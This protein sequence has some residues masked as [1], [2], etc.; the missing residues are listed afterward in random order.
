MYFL[1]RPRET[2]ARTLEPTTK[3]DSR[4]VSGPL[5]D[6][7]PC[8]RDHAVT[9]FKQAISS[10][11]RYSYWPYIHSN[12]TVLTTRLNWLVLP[13]RRSFSRT[14]WHKEQYLLLDWNGW[15]RLS[16]V[17]LPESLASAHIQN[18]P[19]PHIGKSAYW[20]RFSSMI[21]GR[22]RLRPLQI[23]LQPERGHTALALGP[24]D[25][26]ANFHEDWSKN[27]PVRAPRRRA[28]FDRFSQ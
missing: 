15:C 24:P 6:R 2:I 27:V 16:V 10:S 14:R 26:L 21:S 1:A 8:C 25:I 12:K 3:L 22:G 20:P 4:N 28:D 11:W 7:R 17:H 18:F 5:T 23:N 9:K 13:L 19:P